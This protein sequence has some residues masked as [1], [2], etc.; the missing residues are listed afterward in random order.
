M[1]ENTLGLPYPRPRAPQPKERTHEDL[2]ERLQVDA[3]PSRELDALIAAAVEPYLFDAPGFTKIR[4]IPPFRIGVEGEIRFEGGGIMCMSYIPRYT[5]S[6][7]AAVNLA[8]KILPKWAW[9]T[10]HVIGGGYAAYV[11]EEDMDQTSS[12]HILS[13]PAVALCLAILM[14]HGANNG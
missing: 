6:I 8:G 4:P 7:D 5:S 1:V 2:I 3:G 13:S 11:C 10:R 14:A 9:M 12:G